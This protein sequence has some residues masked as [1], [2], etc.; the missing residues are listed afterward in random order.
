MKD[1]VITSQP[2]PACG[3]KLDR[4]GETEGPRRGGEPRPGDLTVCCRC[5]AFL[6]FGSDGILRMLRP[7]EFDTLHPYNQ[8][9]LH[10]VRAAM[11][12]MALYAIARAR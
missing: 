2:C 11:L 1:H 5:T 7:E 9:M 3:H 6:T 10:E 12:E 8:R 4:A